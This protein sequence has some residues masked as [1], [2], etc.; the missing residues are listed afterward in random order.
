MTQQEQGSA[1]KV[2]V[3]GGIGAALG[4][5]VATLLASRP[6]LTAPEDEKME[7]LISLLTT[8]V[9]QNQ[10]L[11]EIG[12]GLTM[13]EIILPSDLTLRFPEAMITI[14]PDPEMLANAG[15]LKVEAGRMFIP[16]WR[17]AL[18]CG[19]GLTTVLPFNIPPG[20]VTYRRKPL[21]VSSDLYAPLIGLNVYSDNTLIN[22]VAPMPITGPFSVDM[23]EY[24]TQWTTLTAEV[25]NGTLFN[26]VVSFQVCTYL[27]DASF[28]DEFI[29]PIIDAVQQKVEAIIK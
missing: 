7:Y 20:W 25:I 24:V 28:W 26:A 8:L 14:P 10:K 17:T 15:Q 3:S 16:T 18:A 22:P 1:A 6:T 2:L 21:E 12:E 23:G 9:Q 29:V 27:M 5:T 11:I 13:P 4:A 19:A